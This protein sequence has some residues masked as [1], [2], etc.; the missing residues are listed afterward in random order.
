MKIFELSKMG[1]FHINNNEDAIAIQ[2]I[3][4]QQ[5]LVAVMDGCSMGKESH[6]ASTMTAKVLRKTAKEFDYKTFI[7]K[8]EKSSDFLLK[9]VLKILFIELR[10][11]KNRWVLETD[12]LLNTLILGIL[13]TGKR[14]ISTITIG[15]GLI[16]CNGQ[17]FEYEQ[18]DKPDYLGYHLHEDFDDW[19]N[20]QSQHLNL[21]GIQDIS[22]C[23]DGIFSFRN[24]DN[25]IYEKTTESDLVNF[26]T[27]NTEWS[28]QEN[29]LNRKLIGIEKEYGLRPSDDLSIIRVISE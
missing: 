25:G 6:F 5:L 15:D 10:D 1:Q 7:D 29:M 13:N 23:T 17:H 21:N 14:S 22:I 2:E 27:I 11:I 28:N 4:N 19:F 20:S 3:G 24:F 8:K 18:D 26:L 12:E 9:E 16:V